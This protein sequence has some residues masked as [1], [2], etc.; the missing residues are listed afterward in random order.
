M[1]HVQE[2]KLPLFVGTLV[3]RIFILY[4]PGSSTAHQSRYGHRWRYS[5]RLWH[6]ILYQLISAIWSS[7]HIC[8]IYSLG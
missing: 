1:Q 5:V 8:V 6:R 7:D 4:F 2:V 3:F